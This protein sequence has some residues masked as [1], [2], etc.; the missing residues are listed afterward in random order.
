ML[1]QT[2]IGTLTSLCTALSVVFR[3]V[4]R[5]GAAESESMCVFK[6]Y[7]Y[8]QTAILNSC[9]YCTSNERECLFPYTSGRG[10][11]FFFLFLGPPVLTE[12]AIMGIHVSLLPLKGTINEM[13]AK[14]SG[15][16]LLSG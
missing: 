12:V 9:T 3:R 5:G 7:I 14:I 16:Y 13:F 15:R 1:E 4:R 6:I 10:S 11:D 2:S 8:C